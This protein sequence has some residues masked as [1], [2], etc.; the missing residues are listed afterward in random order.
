MHPPHPPPPCPQLVSSGHREGHRG[1]ELQVKVGP[2]TDNHGHHLPWRASHFC[3]FESLQ[4]PLWER[5]A[6]LEAWSLLL[7]FFRDADEE[8]VWV[9]EK[10]SL[11]TAQDYGQSLSAVWHLQK[12]HQNLEREMRSHEALTWAVVGTGHKLVQAGHFAAC[13]VAA[14]VQQ[15]EDATGCLRAEAAQR[16]QRLQ[17]AQ[18]A[19]QVLTELLEAASWLEEQGCVLDTEDMGRRA[20]DTQAFLRRLEATRRKL[21]GFSTYIN[22]LWQ[23]A[24]LLESRQN[25]ER[26]LAQ[27]QVVREAHAGLLQRAEDRGPGL[28]EQLQLHQLEWEALL[29]SSW[30]A[31]KVATAESQ[32]Y[33]QDLEAAKVLEEK[34]DAFRKEVQ[35]LGQAKVQALKELAD[36]LERAAPRGAP[37]IQAQQSRIEAA[38]ERLDRAIK[39][40]TQAGSPKAR[41]GAAEGRR[42]VGCVSLCVAGGGCL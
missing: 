25:P 28:R 26:V 22:R 30:L 31:S 10:L 39:T 3:R 12:Q 35:S 2:N 11:A 32:D 38:W 4:E 37:R 18:G 8:M 20:E 21:Q 40:R 34:F 6:A 9:Q 7:Q 42:Q 17:Q 41:P 13:D 27:M 19:Q 23:T 33:G 15:L 14:R 24:A 5:R 1:G 16:W 29:L 36:S